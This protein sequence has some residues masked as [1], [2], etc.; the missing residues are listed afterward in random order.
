MQVIK[1]NQSLTSI[2]D[3]RQGAKMDE[4]PFGLGTTK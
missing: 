2:V 1:Y 3:I 4:V